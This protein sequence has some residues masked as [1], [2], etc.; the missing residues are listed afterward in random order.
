MTKCQKQNLLDSLFAPK[1]IVWLDHSMTKC[2]KQNLLDSLFAPKTIVWLDHSMTKCQKQDLK[3]S[4]FL[5]PPPADLVASSCH[6]GL[7]FVHYLM[8]V[9][10]F[11]Y[12]W[13]LSSTLPA[14]HHFCWVSWPPSQL[15]IISFW[16]VP[17][18]TVNHFL[19]GWLVS[20]PTVNHFFW[21][22]QHH[23]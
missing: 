15:S 7:P 8:W 5:G 11:T 22:D 13:G 12:S 9:P 21:V 23:P 10:Q 16:L 19:L 14:V 18:P 3:D 17:I 1:T 4:F 6:F 2:Q 20:I